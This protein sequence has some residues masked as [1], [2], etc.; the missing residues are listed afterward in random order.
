MY[1]AE[2]D[3]LVVLDALKQLGSGNAR[4][5]RKGAEDTKLHRS[6]VVFLHLL[7]VEVATVSADVDAAVQKN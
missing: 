4:S 3:Y 1:I 2:S 7:F 5:I 6:T